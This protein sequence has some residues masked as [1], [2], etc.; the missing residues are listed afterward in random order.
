MQDNNANGKVDRA[1]AVFSESLAAYSAGTTP[2]TLTNVPSGGNLT[3]VSVSSATATLTITEGAGAPDTAVDSFTIALAS[4]ATGIRDA[5]GNQANFT[6][7]TPTDGAG[8][9]PVSVT[10]GEQRSHG[11]SDGGRRH[12]RGH[13]QRA[14]RD[15]DRAEHDDHRDGP[16]RCRQ[17]QADDHRASPPPRAS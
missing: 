7:T 4:N 9:V 12:V 14:D 13:V 8:P 16:E 6:T 17:R 15:R 2:W 11:G 10:S 5:A 1:L 3:T